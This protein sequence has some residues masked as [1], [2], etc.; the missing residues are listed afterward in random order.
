MNWIS[1]LF[2]GIMLIGCSE[3]GTSGSTSNTDYVTVKTNGARSGHPLVGTW[4]LSDW[5]RDSCALYKD[6]WDAEYEVMRVNSNRCYRDSA[7]CDTFPTNIDSL[8][9][10]YHELSSGNWKMAMCDGG[11]VTFEEDASCYGSFLPSWGIWNVTEDSLK[12]HLLKLDDKTIDPY[13]A[14]SAEYWIDSDTLHILR[15]TLTCPIQG[16]SR[17]DPRAF[18]SAGFRRALPS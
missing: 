13:Y 5:V 9:R 15:G 14:D 10:Y 8:G 12:I 4:S 3:N 1:L 6:K 17:N 11:Y 2:L 7:V 18:L 16:R